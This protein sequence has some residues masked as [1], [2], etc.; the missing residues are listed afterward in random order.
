MS[1]LAIQDAIVTK[2]KE[3][4]QDVYDD[5][6]PEETKL[7][8]STDGIMLPY[9]IVEH[10]G[11]VPSI[12]GSPISGVAGASGKSSTTILCIGPN[13]RSS[14][15]VAGLVREK[16]TGFKVATSGEL[17]P[18]LAPYTYIDGNARPIRYVTEITFDFIT[19]TVW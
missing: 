11:V 18:S 5:G 14:R 13:Q 8:F 10:A 7:R 12:N 17:T 16:L 3:L 1:L 6:V 19:D 9:I 4:A 15:Q 2:L